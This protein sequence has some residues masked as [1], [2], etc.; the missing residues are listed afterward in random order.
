MAAGDHIDQLK[1]EIPYLAVAF[2]EQPSS[3]TVLTVNNEAVPVSQAGHIPVDPG[4]VKVVVSRPG[5]VPFETKIDLAKR[6]GQ[7]RD[8]ADSRCAWR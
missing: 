6:A 1:P 3:D 8:I 7:R 4:T 2:A 5:R